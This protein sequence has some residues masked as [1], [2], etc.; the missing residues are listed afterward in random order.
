MSRYVVWGLPPCVGIMVEPLWSGPGEF[1]VRPLGVAEGE[2]ALTVEWADVHGTLDTFEVADRVRAKAE[3]EWLGR[4]APVN[5]EAV[6][7]RP[8][9]AAGSGLD[10]GFRV[11]EVPCSP[12][13]RDLRELD[14]LQGEGR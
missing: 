9:S 6:P 10:L 11:P 3:R 1:R 12:C 8:A 2:P 7:E 4:R 13:A 14:E 5:P